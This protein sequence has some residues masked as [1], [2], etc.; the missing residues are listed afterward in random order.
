M[1][2][3]AVSGLDEVWEKSIKSYIARNVEKFVKD[4]ADFLSENLTD[5]GAQGR[6]HGCL[7]QLFRQVSG[8]AAERAG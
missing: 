3:K 6:H 7:G 2:N 8:Y 4:S 1:L 5:E